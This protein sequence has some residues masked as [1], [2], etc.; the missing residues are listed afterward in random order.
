MDLITAL[1]AALTAARPRADDGAR[2]GCGVRRGAA[3]LHFGVLD[4]R[5]TMGRWFGGIGAAAPGA[6]APRVRRR[7]STTLRVEGEDASA[8]RQFARRML[9]HAAGARDGRGARARA[10]RAAAALR[11]RL[12][13][14]AR[15]GDRACA[16]RD[17][18]ASTSTRHAGDADGP[19]QAIG[20]RHLDVRGRRAGRRR[21]AARRAGRRRRR[22]WPGCRFR[23]RGAAS[24]PY[25]TRAP[26]SAARPRRGRS[27]SSRRHPR[28]TSS[29]WRTWC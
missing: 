29:G 14:P 5:G 7:T 15:A 24:S 23:R 11:A 9:A 26:A 20:H 25:R 19:R 28:A 4:L 1:R 17:C 16:R 22:S 21:R 12:R 27:P 3:R 2:R 6:D 18:T 8:P 13:H 10:S